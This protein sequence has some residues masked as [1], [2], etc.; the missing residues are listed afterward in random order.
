MDSFTIRLCKLNSTVPELSCG[1]RLKTSAIGLPLCDR[2][3]VT[4]SQTVCPY[5]IELTVTLNHAAEEEIP[6][7][8]IPLNAFKEKEFPKI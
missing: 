4:K 7:E 2:F 5:M 3:T 8:G 1:N 6:P